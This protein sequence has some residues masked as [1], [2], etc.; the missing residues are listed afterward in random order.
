MDTSTARSAC[1]L[2]W[3]KWQ[4]GEHIDSLP[5][6]LR[7]L[8]IS[9]GYAIQACLER[10]SAH[11]LFGWKIAATSEAGKAHLRVDRPLAGRILAEMLL[12]GDNV[13]SLTG[14]AWRLAEPEFVFRMARDLPPAAAYSEDEVMAAVGGLCLGIELPDCRFTDVVKVG[15]S[16]LVADDACA[17]RYLLGPEAP[18]MWR[19]LD[20]S[21]H[22]V[23]CVVVGRYER[24]GNGGNVMGDP[25][26]A[27]TWLANELSEYGVTLRSGQY[28]T[29][30]TC[31]APLDIEP[32][33]RLIVDYGSL[34]T[35]SLEFVE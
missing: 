34:G 17:H 15:L 4:L 2:L 35:M 29:T 7:P 6:Q 16:Q 30:G 20:L 33:D 27:L 31:A 25:K 18:A 28:V 13:V 1:D 10:Y 8:S 23:H 5:D 12:P 11:P 26:R 21:E 9:D 32:D 24:D 3:R 22:R 14:N 19:R